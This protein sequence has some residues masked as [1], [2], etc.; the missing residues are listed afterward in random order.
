MKYYMAIQGLLNSIYEKS[1]F[2]Q[3]LRSE[4][5]THSENITKENYKFL[6]DTIYAD[7]RANLQM[8]GGIMKSLELKKDIPFDVQEFLNRDKQIIPKQAVA[9]KQ[10]NP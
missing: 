5:D 6:L 1:H 8:L 10:A 9:V 7:S 2:Y 4:Y 3:W